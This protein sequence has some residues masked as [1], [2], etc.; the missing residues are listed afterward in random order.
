MGLIINVDGGARGNPGPA[1]AGVVIRDESG[2]SLFEAGYFL[3]RQTNN[4]AEYTALI[5]ALERVSRMKAESITICSDSQLLVRQITGE[6]RVKSE[7]LATLF[8][9]VQTLLLKQERWSVRH[10]PREENSLA[11][12]LANLAMDQ[13]RDVIVQDWVDAVDLLTPSPTEEA[14]ARGKSKKV[15]AGA[16]PGD[17]NDASTRVID[18][19]MHRAP[20]TGACPAGESLA[21]TWEIQSTLPAGLCIHAAHGIVPT[22]LAM[23]NADPSEFHAIPTLTV[24]CSKP[25]CAA[26]FHV[27]PQ[28]PKNGKH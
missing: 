12:R 21:G 10:I 9:Q 15:D 25:E 20:P 24:R 11:D 26:V 3:G 5:R 19:S 23:V 18:V 8:E 2:A 4:F 13:R 14:K 7:S 27:S 1:G 17:P 22:A 6:Y 28:P 16:T